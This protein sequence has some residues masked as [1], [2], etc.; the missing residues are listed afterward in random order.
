MTWLYRLD[1]IQCLTSIRVSTSRHSYGKT[2]ATIRTMCDPVRMMS[3]IRQVVH[4]KFDHPTRRSSII[5][6]NCVHQFN[7]LDI[8]LQGPNPQSLIMVIT[9]SQSATVQT[10]G[11]HCPNAVLLW[12][13]SMLFWKGNCS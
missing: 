6:R 12:K 7:Y 3:S 11:K 2:T 10:L 1:A 4:T 9:C 8:S 5:Y 13:L